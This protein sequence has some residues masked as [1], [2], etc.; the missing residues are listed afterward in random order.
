MKPSADGCGCFPTGRH[1]PGIAHL[2]KP[3]TVGLADEFEPNHDWHDLP[4]AFLDTETTGTSAEADR[5][6][7]VGS[8]VG[9]SGAVQ[10]RYNWLINPGMPIPPRATEVHGI[11]D[12]DVREQ[13]SFAQVAPE[14]FQILH[15]TLPAAYN[16]NFDRAFLRAEM[17]RVGLLQGE[18]CPPALRNGVEWVDPLVWSR[19][20]YRQERS[21]KLGDVA[22][23]LGVQ[24]QNAHR[25]SDD[26][27]A[28]LL[29]LYILG[30]DERVPR[31]YG[32]LI[33]EQRRLGKIQEQE[34]ARWRNR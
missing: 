18:N 3:D 4:V 17:Q 6:V 13:P 16:A 11:S 9:Q 24:L 15:G 12:E 29:V 14:I 28:A 25:A 33:K 8:I 34:M 10:R 19:H 20:V 7:E 23:R 32:S 26:A 31:R 2:L 5:I 30:R 1:Y 27:E 21:H 22:T